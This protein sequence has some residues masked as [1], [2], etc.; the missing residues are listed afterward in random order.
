MARLRASQ[1]FGVKPVRG[2]DRM[3]APNLQHKGE[4]GFSRMHLTCICAAE[5]AHTEVRPGLLCE[6]GLRSIKVL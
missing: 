2:A 4:A 5:R 6:A 1:T 3:S